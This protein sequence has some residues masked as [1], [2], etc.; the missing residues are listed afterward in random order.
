MKN[1]MAEK[2]LDVQWREAIAAITGQMP[3][4]TPEE[5]VAGL[6]GNHWAWHD[7][8]AKYLPQIGLMS[9]LGPESTIR[10]V[11]QQ[12]DVKPDQRR[13]AECYFAAMKKAMANEEEGL[14]G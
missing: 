4:G 5:V 14:H 10:W 2:S 13:M 6:F 7:E 8:I 11:F 9:F 1:E 3:Q 12:V